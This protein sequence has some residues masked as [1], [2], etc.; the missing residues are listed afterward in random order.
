MFTA[1]ADDP[2]TRWDMR[3]PMDASIYRALEE[4]LGKSAGDEVEQYAFTIILSRLKLSYIAV[5]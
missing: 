1:G 3:L 4:M 5:V 2:V